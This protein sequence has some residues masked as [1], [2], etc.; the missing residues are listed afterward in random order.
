M[1]IIVITN[2]KYGHVNASVELAEFF[3]KQGNDVYFPSDD[4]FKEKIISK[5]INYIDY[6]KEFDYDYERPLPFTILNSGSEVLRVSR[7][8]YEKMYRYIKKE[9]FDLIVYDRVII[10]G[11][12]LADDLDIPAVSFSTLPILNIDIFRKYHL[13]GNALGIDNPKDWKYYPKFLRE[14]YLLSRKI[15]KL[16]STDILFNIMNNDVDINLVFTSRGIQPMG[17]VLGGRY[18]YIGV[19]SDGNEDLSKL[20]FEVEEN[21]VYASLGTS[22]NTDLDF[23]RNLIDVFKDREEQLILSIPDRFARRL[24]ISK[25]KNIVSGEYLPQR[26]ILKKVKYFIT[27]GGF[28][29]VNEA[30]YDKVPMVVVP[31]MIE[32]RLNGMRVEELGCGV[33]CLKGKKIGECIG[34]MDSNYDTYKENVSEVSKWYEQ[35]DDWDDVYEDIVRWVKS[36]S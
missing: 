36:N 12:L 24:K 33:N 17:D 1:K 22:F 5:G 27:H 34:E 25:Y 18:R 8:L 7:K 35:C 32:Q 6:I 15:P 28:N 2:T 30:I 23:Y 14:L 13:L 29:S 9:K 31:Q 4:K 11:R 20:D 16:S 26:A 21:A 3:V 10:W 19:A